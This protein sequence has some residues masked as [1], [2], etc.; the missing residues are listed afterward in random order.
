V[1]DGRRDEESL[2]GILPAQTEQSTRCCCQYRQKS[3]SIENS[4]FQDSI[5]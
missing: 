2:P 4:S 3:P 5:L 1:V